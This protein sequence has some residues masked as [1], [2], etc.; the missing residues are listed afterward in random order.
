MAVADLMVLI[1]E[2]ILSEMAGAYYPY[3]FLNLYHICKLRILFNC[4]SIDCS[5]WLTV[6]FTFDR[7]VTICNQSLRVKYC[8]EK[9]AAV[10]ITVTCILSIIQNIPVYIFL[11]PLYIIDNVA[12]YCW[13]PTDV[14]ATPIGAAL[15]VMET[16]VT[17]VI[18]MLLIIL[19]NA[20]T[21]KHI[22]HSNRVRSGL[23]RDNKAGSG[24]DQEVENRRKSII[25]LLAISGNFVLLWMVTFV[26]FMSVNFLDVHL[27]GSD[28]NDPFTI[29]EL[30]GYM[31]RA[32]SACTNTFIY[33]VSQNKFREEFKNV[34]KSPF[35]LL[36]KSIKCL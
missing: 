14:Y 35:V 10:V 28:Y 6:T 27:L 16:I 11:V 33:G 15:S 12:W 2:V 7:F 31:L 5:V 1:F 34:I 3:S 30:S 25:L 24:A 9:T 18:P 22:I 21:I 32:V 29:A 36:F 13:V 19:L 26:C 23:R 20:L 17:P 4:I 8:T